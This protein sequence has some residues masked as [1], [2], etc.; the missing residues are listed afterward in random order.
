MMRQ[1]TINSALCRFDAALNK[2]ERQCECGGQGKMSTV[3]KEANQ[4]AA[5]LS[6]LLFSISASYII[7][8]DRLTALAPAAS[9]E[10]IQTAKGLLYIVLVSGFVFL[11]SRRSF[12]AIYSSAKQRELLLQAEMDR[13][14]SLLSRK[15]GHDIRNLVATMQLNL[16]SFEIEKPAVMTD[17]LEDIKY[18]NTRLIELSNRL[19]GTPATTR[20][21]DPIHAAVGYVT[22]LGKTLG[23]EIRIEN[24]CADKS[25]D[26]R[27]NIY[28]F[29]QMLSNLVLNALEAS[30][31]PGSVIVRISAGE[32]G[33]HIEV[34][35]HGAGIPPAV[36]EQIWTPLFT[37]KETG[38]GLG[39][40]IV[41]DAVAAFQGEVSLESPPEG[42]TCFRILIP[43]SMTPDFSTSNLTT[44]RAPG[45]SYTYN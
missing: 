20:S 22:F 13:I 11:L 36:R 16:A 21:F 38:T 43:V 5:V 6:L 23:K 3:P 39:L 26:L 28:L 37:T 44:L 14:T 18:V 25:F 40:T 33:L 32:R 10:T 35:D 41:R 45:R 34:R 31:E 19:R 17:A 27:G 4:K 9:W 2:F 15:V 8:S 42:G 24:L 1:K 30:P 29:E 7:V 12:A